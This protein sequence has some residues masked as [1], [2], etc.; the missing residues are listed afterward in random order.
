MLQD[1]HVTVSMKGN[2]R[3]AEAVRFGAETGVAGCSAFSDSVCWEA[4][5]SHGYRAGLHH[6]GA[7]SA[8]VVNQVNTYRRVPQIGEI[9]F[10]PSCERLGV[11]QEQGVYTD[12]FP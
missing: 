8:V 10:E 2:D 12:D 11:Y 5:G 6:Y 1:E 7:R 4:S 9:H 3:V